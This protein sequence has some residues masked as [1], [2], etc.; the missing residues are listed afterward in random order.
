VDPDLS[1][2]VGLV[3]AVLTV[4]SLISAYVEGRPPRAG[5]IFV[6]IAG[7]L[8]VYAVSQ[9]PGG[10]AIAEIPDVFFRVIGRYAN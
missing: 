1:L 5:A 9:Q 8:I 7:G 3:L 10:Y 6:L 4:P 2:V